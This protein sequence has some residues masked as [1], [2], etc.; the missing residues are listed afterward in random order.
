MQL[1]LPVS[2]GSPLL[3]GAHLVPGWGPVYVNGDTTLPGRTGVAIIGSRRSSHEG[4][5]LAATIAASLAESSI[6][7]ISGFAAGIDGVAHE[8]AISA[9]GRTIAV[10]GTSLDQA[11]PRE[12]ASLQAR[13]AQ[14]HLVVSPF[15][16]G[17]PMAP[18][19]FP[20]RNRLMAQLAST[21]V[22]VEASATSGTRH[23][24]AACASLG[25]P[26][27]VPATLLER[28]EWLNTPSVRRYVRTWRE[29]ADVLALVGAQN[30]LS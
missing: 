11:Y 14:N 27:L 9:G 16:S 7:I 22:L 10:V 15:A 8:A 3:R 18:W 4:R 29:P 2:Q 24:V 30:A 26:V 19:H 17:T 23:Q 20:R 21:T 12:H 25:R 28:L 6:V 1:S 13:I 5:D